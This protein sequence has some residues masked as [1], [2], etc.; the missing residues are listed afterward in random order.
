MDTFILLVENNNHM[1]ENKQ[2]K[3]AYLLPGSGGT[4]Y[5]GNCLRDKIF[6]KSL[7]ESG[8]DILMIPMYLPLNLDEYETDSPIFYGAVNIYLEQ[9]HPL[10]K[11]LPIWIKKL[12]DS[13]SILDFAAKQ[14]AST[15]ANGH[16]E[17]TISMLKGSDGKQSEDLDTLINWLKVHEKPNVVHISNALLSGMAKKIKSELNCKV[18]CTLQDEDEWIDEMRPIYEA[19]TWKLIEEN[20]KYIDAFIAVSDYFAKLISS[21][22]NIEASKMHV[23]HNFIGHDYI[24]SEKLQKSAP[25]I[26]Y[27]SKINSTFGADILF[28]AYVELK[29]EMPLLKLIYTGGFTDDYKKIISHIKK[30][31]KKLGFD[32]DIDFIEDLSAKGK[33]KFLE[34]ISVYCVPSRR[35]EAFGIHILE[36][37]AYGVPSVMPDIGAYSEIISKSKAGILYD[38]NETINLSNTLREILTNKLLY[39]E[40]Q[41]NCKTSISSIFD[42][43]IQTNKILEIYKKCLEETG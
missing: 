32:T 21:K 2:I 9:L 18:V 11:K 3:I 23:V 16:E 36:A 8:H 24:H 29:K 19:E 37:Q 27:M 34:S 17:M 10:F 41:Q 33:Q 28:D 20:A 40:L 7:K 35:K 31:S 26:G 1:A 25:T 14:S 15:N 30:K 5:C 4:F 39:K 43:S 38:P 13:K 12:L 42:S 6:V 22:V